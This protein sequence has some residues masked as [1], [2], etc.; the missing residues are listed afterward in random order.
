MLCY[1]RLNIF[2][3]FKT[4]K[5]NYKLYKKNNKKTDFSIRQQNVL[6]FSFPCIKDPL[7]IHA[8]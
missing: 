5:A 8:I 4:F 1:T 3:S 6:T 7:S 2:F